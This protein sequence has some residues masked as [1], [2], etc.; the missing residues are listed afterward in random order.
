MDRKIV[1][2]GLDGATLDLIRPWARQGKLPNLA[3]LMD[4]GVSGELRSTVP[5]V[6]A[7][8][9]TSFMTGKNP[10]KHGI[11]HFRTFDLTKYTSFTDDLATSR[12]FANDTIFKLASD[13][14]L[15]V[16]ALAVPMTYPPFPVN[17]V[18]LSGYPTPNLQTAYTYPPDMA[19]RFA[20]IN[21]TSE[22]FRH[23]DPERIR[24][25]THM[26]KQLT[27][28]CV[29]LMQED[30]YD[31]LMVVYTNTDMANHFF[32]KYVH[33]SYPTY[34]P[35]GAAVYGD[36]LLN[37]YQLADQAVGRLVEQ[38]GSDATVLIMSDHGS[39]VHSTQY[40][41]TNSWLNSKGWLAI[42]SDLSTGWARQLRVLLEYIR[43]RTPWAR[44]FVKRRFPRTVKS[45]ITAGLQATSA[46]DWSRT[47][48]YRVPMFYFVEGIQINVRGRQPQGMV[49]PGREYEE[50]RD[51]ILAELRS[52]RDPVTGKVLVREA[53]KKE[54][55]Y[56]GPLLDRA[57]DIVVF[58]DHDYAGGPN[59][60]GA[61]I[62]PIE[63]VT[64]EKWSGLHRMNGTLMMWGQDVRQGVVVEGASIVDPAP[65]ILYLLGLPI[66]A[67]MDGQVLTQALDPDLVAGQ[68]VRRE[69]RVASDEQDQHGT[70]LD[71][72]EEEEIREALRGFG[73]I[74]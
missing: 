51:E 68:P 8:A 22:F 3:R 41:H 4:Q 34:D 27:D 26:V 18:M 70:Y 5:P 40:F 55:E 49:E 9:W 57:P 56:T 7:P 23:S 31:L 20:N 63:R 42:K 32:R 64:L 2:I 37:Q 28:Y 17:G 10:A 67:D 25:A 71:S 58:Y 13:A 65:T 33:E 59:P 38:A 69:D 50:F 14:G 54:Q 30:H 73:Y 24:S 35:E 60:S 36:V 11:F 48:A 12:S 46:I 72:D 39:G 66:P 15:R 53:I 6:T 62:T 16:A 52:L 43:I 47:K 29:E 45:R 1:I 74:D 19:N 61:T 44:D 21:I